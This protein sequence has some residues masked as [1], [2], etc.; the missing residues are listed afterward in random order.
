MR[1]SRTRISPNLADICTPVLRYLR[2]DPQDG[3]AIREKKDY[4]DWKLGHSGTVLNTVG[5]A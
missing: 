2:E 4:A 1:F 3:P 5:Q